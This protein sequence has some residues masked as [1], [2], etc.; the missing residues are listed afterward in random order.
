MMHTTV[1]NLLTGE[2]NPLSMSEFQ[3]WLTYY[4]LKEL[5]EKQGNH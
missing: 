1:E 3:N 4:K 2:H 5:R